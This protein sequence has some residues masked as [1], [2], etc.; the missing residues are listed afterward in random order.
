RGNVQD[1]LVGDR[2]VGYLLHLMGN[3]QEARNY[4]E[5]MLADYEPPVT[6]AQIIRY[7]FD[8]RA[9]AQ[10]FLARI[11]WLQGFADQAKRLVD[12]IVET[13]VASKNV[14]SLC[15]VLV[16]AACPVALYTGDLAAFERH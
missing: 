14:L 9:T 3:Q 7:V 16:Q 10:C 1:S 13:A 2:M 6:G 15:Q 5:R 4:I 11:L 12:R 8:Q